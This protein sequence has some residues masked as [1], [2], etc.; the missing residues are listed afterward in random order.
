MCALSQTA[1]VPSVSQIPV[2]PARKA[3]LNATPQIV[4]KPK[5]YET[6]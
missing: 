2:S 3:A 4:A 6:T 1:A 5:G